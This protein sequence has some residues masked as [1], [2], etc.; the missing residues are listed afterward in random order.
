MVGPAQND[1]Q[2]GGQFCCSLIYSG[3]SFMILNQERVYLRLFFAQSSF[4]ETG[5]AAPPPSPHGSQCLWL[6]ELLMA[7]ST[8]SPVRNRV[9]TSQL[10]R[11][12]IHFLAAGMFLL[13]TILEFDLMYL[14]VKFRVSILAIQ[15]YQAL[16]EYL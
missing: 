10:L 5:A 3:G 9:L 11:Q 12:S 7:W 1:K 4:A 8:T 2:R 16:N 13:D 6:Q 14:E 15:F